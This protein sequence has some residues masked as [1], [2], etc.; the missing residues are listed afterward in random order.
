MAGALSHLARNA[1]NRITIPE[2]GAIFR[3]VQLL[4]PG[5]PPEV[6]KYAAGALSN[7][8]QSAENVVTIA[9]AGAIPP[10]VQLLLSADVHVQ[11]GQLVQAAAV[12]LA[13]LSSNA[14]SS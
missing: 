7:L 3:L 14:L 4:G 6:Q 2:A 11:S 1:E 10:L 12:A 9:A 8:A 5:S 13:N